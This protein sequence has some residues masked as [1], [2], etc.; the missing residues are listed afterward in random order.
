M[1]P[2]ALHAGEK[3]LTGWGRGFEPPL[4]GPK[5]GRLTLDDP[6]PTRPASILYQSPPRS[7]PFST[8]LGRNFGIRADGMVIARPVRGLRP[9]RAAR[10]ATT[11]V[12]NPL[13]ET[14]SRRW[15]ASRTEEKKV[16]TAR[17][18][19]TFEPPEAR[20][21]MATR[22]ALVT[23]LLYAPAPTV[24]MVLRRPV[25]SHLSCTSTMHI[26]TSPLPPCR[27]AAAPVARCA[28]DII[29][30]ARPPRGVAMHPP[31]DLPVAS[32]APRSVLACD[33][34]TWATSRR[35]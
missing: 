32:L 28:C 21:T 20:A 22:S 14:R 25:N 6:P 15:S 10:R 4:P 26:D 33:A 23:R 9:L 13:S 16:L 1:G 29:A 18:A 8:R 34:A 11:K 2:S 19:A 17:S 3:A 5:P 35:C 7:P 30:L 24:S 31:V 27:A 12:P